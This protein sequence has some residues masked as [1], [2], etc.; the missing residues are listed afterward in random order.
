MFAPA[1]DND[2]YDRGT[3]W[4][5][6]LM[7]RLGYYKGT[8][9][10]EGLWATRNIESTYTMEEVQE[11]L[12]SDDPDDRLKNLVSRKPKK[13]SLA[14]AIDCAKASGEFVKYGTSITSSLAENRIL[15]ESFDNDLVGLMYGL[16]IA[17]IFSMVALSRFSRSAPL[18][19]TRFLILLGGVF[20]AVLSI[21]GSYGL[22][23]FTGLATSTVNIIAPCLCLALALDDIFVYVQMIGDAFNARRS[24]LN[25]LGVP[26][27][28]REKDYHHKVYDR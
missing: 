16:I 2:P 5:D 11:A 1:N 18:L 19:T 6:S 10:A 25:K 20:S 4:H 13:N 21:I 3:V 12:Y 22:L 28:V 14:P 24:H 7:E 26:V 15:M 23:G 17:V 9:T 8:W 27:T